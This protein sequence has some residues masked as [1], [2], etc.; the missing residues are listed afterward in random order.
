MLIQGILSVLA[1][2]VSF[3][4]FSFSHAGEPRNLDLLKQDL[5]HYHDSGEYQKDIARVIQQAK[6]YLKTRVVKNKLKHPNQKVAIILD[7]DETA[8]SNYPD[9]LKLNFGGGLAEIEEAEGQGHDPAIKPTLALYQYAKAHD[10]AVFFIT[11]RKEKYREV[12]T[13]N[14]EKVGYKNYDGLYLLP[15]DYH[16]KSVTAFKTGIRKQLT[17]QGYDIVL[18]LSDQ[19]VDLHGGYAEKAFK[20]PDPYYLVA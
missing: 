18:S 3:L 4:T 17:E 12:T 7:I 1:L 6:A 11:A 10:V 2:M 13:A 15:M 14:L 19:Q 5:I 8:L 16:E 9:M 20:L